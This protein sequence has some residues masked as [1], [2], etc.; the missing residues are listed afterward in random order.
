MKGDTAMA[1]TEQTSE[2]T[3]DRLQEE[4]EK[5][6]AL[7]KNREVERFSWHML[8][9]KRLKTIHDLLCPLFGSK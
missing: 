2:I 4:A 7:L 6:V 1:R 9:N 3:H 5:L 8:L